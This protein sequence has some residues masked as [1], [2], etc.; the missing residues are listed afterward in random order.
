MTKKQNELLRRI[1][2]KVGTSTLT[3]DRGR[4]DKR[5]IADL[6][7]QISRQAASGAR[8]VLVTSGAIRAG[9]ERLK[10]QSRP[11]TIPEKQAAAA[12]GQGLLLHTYSELF[13]EAGITAAQVLL[14]RDDFAD[15]TRY[16][17][18]R[19]T[20]NTLLEYGCVPIINENDTIAIDEIK[21]GD[22]DTLAALVAAALNADL[23]ILLSDVPGL[24]DRG[25]SLPG[26]RTIPEVSVITPEI[27]AIAGDSAGE[28]GTGGMKAKVDAAEIATSSGVE[29]VIADG[30]RPDII[31]AVVRREPVGT[32][33]LAGSSR[34]SHRKRWIAYSSPIRGTITVN[35]GAKRMITEG[36]KSLL[37]AGIVD[38]A[39]SFSAGDLV[40]VADER[41]HRLARGF[42]NYS[43]SE[44]RRIKGL[45]TSEIESVL[46]HKDFDEVIH[47][48][49]LVL[50]V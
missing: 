7:E 10:L 36:G 5:Y 15:R 31:A 34:L 17:N 45:K 8:C 13:A 25:P 18:A 3:D 2:V 39:G 27:R 42:A 6:V 38:V 40:A 12:V 19:N 9:S 1:V 47:R 37:P 41:A 49:N 28:A 26:S 35:E 48:D 14:T 50:G 20:L 30:R 44:I 4:I 46:G 43:A 29:M 24:Y 21:F 11:R 33:F 22:N 23:L 32:R 16:L